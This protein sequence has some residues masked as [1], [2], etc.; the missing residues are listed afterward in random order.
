MRLRWPKPDTEL[1]VLF[2]LALCF[3]LFA[4]VVSAVTWWRDPARWLRSHG[5]VNIHDSVS[6]ELNF[7]GDFTR[8]IR[9]DCSEEVFHQFAE[10]QGLTRGSTGGTTT[11]PKNWPFCDEPWWTPPRSVDDAYFRYRDGGELRL[12]DHSSGHLYYAIFVW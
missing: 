8:F 1:G 4:G 2:Y 10:H 3:G 6:S 9:A 11:R 12:M 7:T 5:A